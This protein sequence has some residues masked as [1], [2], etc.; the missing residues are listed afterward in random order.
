[1]S[2]RGV[3]PLSSSR[4]VMV[5]VNRQ[6]RESCVTLRS[7]DHGHALLT[8]R[9]HVSN[10]CPWTLCALR[11]T[12]QVFVV[13][14]L[15]HASTTS[16]MLIALI[17]SDFWPSYRDYVGNTQ[18]GSKDRCGAGGSSTMIGSPGRTSPSART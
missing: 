4:R 3:Q 18:T 15:N 6:D 7:F 12:L 17:A 1:M 11:M 13:N 2:C 5:S 10:A 9:G 16:T 8:C 14:I